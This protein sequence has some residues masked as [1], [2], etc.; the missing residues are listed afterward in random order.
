MKAAIGILGSCEALVADSLFSFYLSYVSAKNLWLSDKI[1]TEPSCLHLTGLITGLIIMLGIID[2][3]V[4]S[5]FRIIKAS[6]GLLIEPS[7]Y[8]LYAAM[9]SILAN[10]LLY[11][12]CLCVNERCKEFNGLEKL[13][14]YELSDGLRLSIIVSSIALISVCISRYFSLYADGIA[15]MLIVLIMLIPII[16][17]LKQSVKKSTERLFVTNDQLHA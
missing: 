4:F 16:N 9:I 5:I 10:Q 7:P 2:V 14:R 13:K 3:F 12:S 11:R 1:E 6:N 17:L 15:G 8:A